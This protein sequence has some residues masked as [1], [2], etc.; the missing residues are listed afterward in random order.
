MNKIQDYANGFK[1][2]G[3]KFAVFSQ[4]VSLMLNMDD[5]ETTINK[6]VSGVKDTSEGEL[7]L[8]EYRELVTLLVDELAS[9]HTIENS[10]SDSTTDKVES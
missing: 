6:L 3:E 9:A 1:A 4:L 8:D 7:N 10:K 5:K 2:D